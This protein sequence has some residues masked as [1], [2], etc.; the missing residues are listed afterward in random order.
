MK[1]WEL[2]DIKTMELVEDDSAQSLSDGYARVKI[3]HVAINQA[4]VS[5]YMGRINV[6][7]PIVPTRIATGLIS[8]ARGSRLNKG[9]RVLLSSYV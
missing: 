9:Q 3:T 4:D 1:R 5:A 6:S 2:K 7:H 8:E